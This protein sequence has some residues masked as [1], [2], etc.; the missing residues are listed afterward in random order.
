MTTLPQTTSPDQPP[1]AVIDAAA[2]TLRVGITPHEASSRLAIPEDSDLPDIVLELADSGTQ[3]QSLRAWG[4]GGG[5]TARFLEFIEPLMDPQSELLSLAEREMIATVVSSA[6][7][8]VS[9][10]LVHSNTLGEL[11]GDHARARRIAVNFRSVALSPRERT[12]ALFAHKLTKY[13]DEVGD[14][15]IAGLRAFG[16]SDEA[17]FEVIAVVAAFNF[18]NRVVSSLGTRPDPQFFAPDKET[19]RTDSGTGS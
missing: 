18:T 11:I 3:S 7:R 17:I 15:D 14:A 13:P 9:C 10:T 6:N 1:H 2:D 19:D 16:M 8:C 12:V 5:T 4:I